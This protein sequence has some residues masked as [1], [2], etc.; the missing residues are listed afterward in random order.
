MKDGYEHQQE[1]HVAVYSTDYGNSIVLTLNDSIIQ[2]NNLYVVNVS[3]SNTAGSSIIIQDLIISKF[4]L[5]LSAVIDFVAQ[6][7]Y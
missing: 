7:F 4:S 5:V 2:P 6:I 3:A 1:T